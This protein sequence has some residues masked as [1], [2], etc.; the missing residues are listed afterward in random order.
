MSFI[1][2]VKN[3]CLYLYESSIFIHFKSNKLAKLALKNNLTN[4]HTSNQVKIK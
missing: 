4:K 1:F 3:E 2:C